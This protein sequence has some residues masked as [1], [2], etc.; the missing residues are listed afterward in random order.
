MQSVANTLF[1]LVTVISL[2]YW[3]VYV[4]LDFESMTYSHMHISLYVTLWY[5]SILA[6][7]VENIWEHQSDE[8][9]MNQLRLTEFQLDYHCTRD[10]DRYQKQL[11]LG[12]NG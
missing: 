1:N 4:G 8:L 3:L 5:Q 11:V 12:S 9:S 6:Q 10:C 7:Q 2:V